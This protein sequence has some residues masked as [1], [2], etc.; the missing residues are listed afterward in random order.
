MLK[1]LVFYTV[2][3]TVIAAILQAVGANIGVVLFGGLIGPPIILLVIRIID[4][5]SKP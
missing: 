1:N 3:G 4:Y 5:N 2:A